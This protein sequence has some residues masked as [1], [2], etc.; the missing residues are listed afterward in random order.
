[1]VSVLT[2]HK[3]DK[4][5]ASKPLKAQNV[6]GSDYSIQLNLS[7]VE[8]HGFS[9]ILGRYINEGKAKVEDEYAYIVP[10]YDQY[11][12]K[13]RNYKI[14]KLLEYV[15]DKSFMTMM[16]HAQITYV[17]P[18]NQAKKQYYFVIEQNEVQRHQCMIIA[19]LMIDAGLAVIGEKD[20]KLYIIYNYKQQLEK[21]RKVQRDLSGFRI[22]L[23]ES[24]NLSTLLNLFEKG[25]MRGGKYFIPMEEVQDNDFVIELMSL[26]D[27]G[28][29]GYAENSEDEGGFVLDT[30]FASWLLEHIS[31]TSDR[32]SFGDLFLS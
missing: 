18:A 19:A 2:K 1:M 6:Y 8:Q 25:E 3:F 26:V 23:G 17:A 32:I 9:S 29:V 27:I 16:N 24:S 13:T 30:F 14:E 10:E 21:N 31:N 5:V 22:L 15:S 7:E 20:A 28:M 4:F 11:Q 12:M